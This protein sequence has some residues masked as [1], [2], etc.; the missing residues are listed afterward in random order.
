MKNW[1]SGLAK[2]TLRLGKSVWVRVRQALN[3]PLEPVEP[4][5]K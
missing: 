3:P 5:G 1:I 2:R 4:D